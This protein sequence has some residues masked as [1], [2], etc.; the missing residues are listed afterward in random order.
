LIGEAARARFGDAIR[1]TR[2]EHG[3]EALAVEPARVV[4]LLRFLRDEPDLAFAMLLDVTAVDGL[5][6][7][8]PERFRVVYHLY[9]PSRN[10]RVRVIAALPN[11]APLEV[12]SAFA[13]WKNADWLERETF[14]QYGIAFAGHPNL[15]RL[16][17]HKDFVGH[18][19]RKD[20]DI[21]KG[22]WLSEPDAL[23]DQLEKARAGLLPD[24]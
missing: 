10:E 12:P 6:R 3:V 11:D 16:L 9:S 15:V 5:Q 23:L 18:P 21:K 1:E 13:L 8:W 14:D 20:Y 4:D 17:N 19:L 22:Q 7:P 2:I 24:N